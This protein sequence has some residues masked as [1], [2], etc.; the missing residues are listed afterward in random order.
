LGRRKFLLLYGCLY[1]LSPLLFTLIGVWHPMVLAGES[2]SFAIFIAFATLYPN[3]ALLFNILA[4]WAALI[5]VGLSTLAA[6]AY[7]DWVTLVS[8]WATV[9]FAFAFVRCE[10]GR[11]TLPRIN[12]FGKKPKLRVLPGLKPEKNAGAKN[13]KA[14]PIGEIDGLLDK[15]AES[16]MSSLTPKERARLDA[17]RADL[18][19]KG[20]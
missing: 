8:L 14:I 16:G 4:K 7:H 11:F 18:L 19:K 10:Q 6:L 2:C 17:A 1:L 5:L 15:I 13:P 3:V 12:L 9:G 20:R